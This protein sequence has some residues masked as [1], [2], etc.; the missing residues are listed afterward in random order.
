MLGLYQGGRGVVQDGTE[1][2][3]A[4]N[5]SERQV[6]TAAEQDI[7]D[8]IVDHFLIGYIGLIRFVLIARGLRTSGAYTVEHEGFSL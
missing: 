8:S 3:K 1:Q 2:W 6:G 7:I 4:D 5:L